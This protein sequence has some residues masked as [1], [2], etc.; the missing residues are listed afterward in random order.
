ML[1]ECR[2]YVRAY[3]HARMQK[4]MFA[5]VSVYVCMCARIPMVV[6]QNVGGMHMRVC[7]CMCVHCCS[8][9]CIRSSSNNLEH[10]MIVTHSCTRSCELD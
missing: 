10:V 1:V 2:L 9:L 3:M 5:Y 6:R 8:P 4:C 7:A